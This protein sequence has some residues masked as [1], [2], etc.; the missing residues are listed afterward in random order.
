MVAH[1]LDD[2]TPHLQCALSLL[3]LPVL[4]R[5][6]LLKP[7]VRAEDVCQ[8]LG[9]SRSASYGL[10][11]Q[12]FEAARGVHRP[13]GRPPKSQTL[14]PV[15]TSQLVAT[16]VVRY[17]MDNPG[18]VVPGRRRIYTDGFRRFVIRLMGPGGPGETLTAAEVAEAIDVPVRTFRDWL[19]TPT[20]AD[21]TAYSGDPVP[22]EAPRSSDP[23]AGEAGEPSA[24]RPANGESVETATSEPDDTDTAGT[25]APERHTLP[26]VVVQILA[27]W[28]QWRGGF[29]AFVNML[30][31]HRIFAKAHDVR[32]ILDD[33]AD[34][35]PKRRGQGHYDA[36]AGRGSMETFYPNAQ[37][38]ADGKEVF[39]TINRY[40]FKFCWQALVDGTTTTPTGSAIR[41]EEDGPGL[42][43]TIRMSKRTTGAA[44]DAMTR[45]GKPCNYSP[46]VESALEADGIISVPATPNR[47]QSKS[48]VEGL[49]GLFEQYLPP[50]DIQAGSVKRLAREILRHVVTAY[51]V[52]RGQAPRAA[53]GGRS[54]R[55]AFEQ[56]RPTE[57]QRRE[58]RQRLSEIRDRILDQQ[59]AERRRTDPVCR[60][61]LDEAFTDFGLS[62]PAG[63]II[64]TIA[65]Y[66]LDAV[67][68]AIAIFRHKRDA[69][70]LPKHHHERYLL[71]IAKNVAERNED[72]AVY[73]ET[74]RLRLQARDILLQPLVQ[75]AARLADPLDLDDYIDTCLDRALDAE[76]HIDRQF[77]AD[78]CMEAFAT[79]P[80]DVRRQRGS[81]MARQIATQ[82]R[83]PRRD[84][85]ILLAA[86][87]RATTGRMA[88]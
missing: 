38:F 44:P 3:S 18:C 59:A 39:V 50:I 1:L 67:L 85:D 4:R 20:T 87:A 33:Y 69:G 76:F 6:V 58:A 81:N 72:V 75:Q 60:A 77:W 68:E 88:A 62:D 70:R 36:E 66:G 31:Q 46:E 49:F 29:T 30:G 8:G 14:A 79:Q 27:L 48:P 71:G 7:D 34:R 55:E 45:D 80:D 53:L 26:G 28:Q 22:D 82:Y 51:C 56:D 16:A 2:V 19:A 13:R 78:T 57:E 32:Q 24:P 25:S 10:A 11:G 64:T 40:T 21:D 35:T 23:D 15:S 17:L 42:T 61:K 65:R 41:D 47:G 73:R 37:L 43:E 86:L 74:I 52:G 12:I 5:L 84:R 9:V 54:P 83:L 63:T